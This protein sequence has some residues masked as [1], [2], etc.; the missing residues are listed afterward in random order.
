MYKYSKLFP[1]LKNLADEVSDLIYYVNDVKPYHTKIKDVIVQYTFVEDIY[2]T[3][4]ET[5]EKVIDFLIDYNIDERGYDIHRYDHRSY[6]GE[7]ISV[8]EYYAKGFNEYGFD[9]E[10]YDAIPI[11]DYFA[12]KSPTTVSTNIKEHLVIDISRY[13]LVG[14]DYFPYDG[15]KYDHTNILELPE[16]KSYIHPL[17]FGDEEFDHNSN[18]WLGFDT[19]QFR[20]ELTLLPI[21]IVEPDLVGFD[22]DEIEFLLKSENSNVLKII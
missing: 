10:H 14:L 18:N 21:S 20:K 22:T 7:L 11:L 1:K 9:S 12:N 19:N 3:I 16:V 17:Y 15:D 6:D 2:T 4:T 5:H 13:K 8:T